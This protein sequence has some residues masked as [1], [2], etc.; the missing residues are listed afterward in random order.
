[1]AGAV[2]FTSMEVSVMIPT[3][4][5]LYRNR[6]RADRKLA[7]A[8]LVLDAMRGGA[9][10]HLEYTPPPRWTLSNGHEVPDEIARLVVASAS[11]VGVG[12]ALFAGVASQTFRWWAGTD[13]HAERAVEPPVF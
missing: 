7:A 13:G 5:S 1:M 11:V 12:D 8:A 6:R 9:A 4:S 10:L 2:S 3:V